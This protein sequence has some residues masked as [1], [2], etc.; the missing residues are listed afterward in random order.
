MFCSAEIDFNQHPSQIAQ[1]KARSTTTTDK[2][3]RISNNTEMGTVTK[4][5]TTTQQATATAT[6]TA[7]KAA[8]ASFEL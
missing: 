3:L 5:L 8:S 6:A 2:F 7:A 4:R 1:Y